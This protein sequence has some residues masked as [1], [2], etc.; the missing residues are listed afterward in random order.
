[1]RI[2]LLVITLVISNICLAQEN[3]LKELSNTVE[4]SWIKTSPQLKQTKSSFF[5]RENSKTTFVVP[6]KI[7]GLGVPFTW[8]CDLSILNFLLN[9][10]ESI[11][12]KKGIEADPNYKGVRI[13]WTKKQNSLLWI[14]GEL[15]ESTIDN[16]YL[17]GLNDCPGTYT[18]PVLN[19]T[20]QYDVPNART[21]SQS[22]IAIFP[23]RPYITDIER[24]ET[25][26]ITEGQEK[27]NGTGF[28]L[29]NDQIIDVFIFMEWLDEEQMTGY[30]RLYMNVDG[31]W[32][33][34]WSEL[35]EECI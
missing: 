6:V 4:S 29:N 28:D 5:T 13:N 20:K 3:V 25:K 19:F 21:N 27:V 30:K 17:F 18:F 33:F 8:D 26:L 23:A 11:T 31:N 12:I 10:D 2:H 15:Y 32:V 34:K 35:Y 24:I 9:K 7:S 14:D 22:G 16:W 1:M